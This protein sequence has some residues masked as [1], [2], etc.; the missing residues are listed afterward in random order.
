[1][2]DLSS[3]SNFLEWSLVMKYGQHNQRNG[4]MMRILGNSYGSHDQLIS[5][6]ENYM[7]PQIFGAHSN[8]RPKIGEIIYGDK[9]MC[10]HVA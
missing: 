10:I 2:D 1:M 7:L 3:T 6:L 4:S 5:F 8:K 9:K